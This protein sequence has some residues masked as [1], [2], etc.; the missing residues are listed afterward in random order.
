MT[1]RIKGLVDLLPA[2]LAPEVER[3]L[4]RL[5]HGDENWQEFSSSAS[6]A[7]FD[8]AEVEYTEEDIPEV[9]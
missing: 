6:A 4:V 7:L 9:A 5:T 3:P 8:E 2:E 1:E